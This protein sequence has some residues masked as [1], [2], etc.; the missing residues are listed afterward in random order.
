MSLKGQGSLFEG[1]FV[2]SWL[3]QISQKVIRLWGHSALCSED[4]GVGGAQRKDRPR[5][6]IEL[7]WIHYKSK[8]TES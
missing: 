4:S 5:D 3:N 7:F 8:K 6:K 1:V 2:T